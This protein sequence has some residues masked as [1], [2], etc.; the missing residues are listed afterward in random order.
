MI[1]LKPGGCYLFQNSLISLFYVLIHQE[2]PLKSAVKKTSSCILDLN[3][4]RHGG[5]SLGKMER[6]VGK[7]RR[8][9]KGLSAS[10]VLEK[11]TIGI[12]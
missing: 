4:G 7:C 3:T 9:W 1:K 2:Q 12:E 10:V 5:N 8:M 6:N 11:N